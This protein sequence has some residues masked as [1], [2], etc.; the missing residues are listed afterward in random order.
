MKRLLNIYKVSQHLHVIGGP[1]YSQALIVNASFN[2]PYYKSTIYILGL[3]LWL[4]H[5]ILIKHIMVT[6]VIQF[7]IKLMNCFMPMFNSKLNITSAAI[8]V[9][10]YLI[11]IKLLIRFHKCTY[12][13]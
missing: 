4:G 2:Q 9:A 11:I 3:H 12:G 10:M 8:N 1:G 6:N 7:Y 5:A 13:L